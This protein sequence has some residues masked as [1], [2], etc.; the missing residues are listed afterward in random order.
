MS[1]QPID[2]V[3]KKSQSEQ[4]ILDQLVMKLKLIIIK[5]TVK[6]VNAHHTTGRG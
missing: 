6:D 5:E 3:V 1:Y 2:E 4:K